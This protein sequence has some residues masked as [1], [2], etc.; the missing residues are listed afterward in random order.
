MNAKCRTSD[1]DTKRSSKRELSVQFVVHASPQF[2][3]T[4]F[5]LPCVYNIEFQLCKV[6]SEF[7]SSSARSR[8]ELRRQ[9]EWLT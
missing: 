8:W 3:C 6:C 4:D 7:N 2:D 9:V 5:T 1:H